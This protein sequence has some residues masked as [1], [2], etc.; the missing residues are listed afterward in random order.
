MKIQPIA[1][2][3]TVTIEIRQPMHYFDKK[4]NQETMDVW[5]QACKDFELRITT[6]VEVSSARFKLDMRC[7]LCNNRWEVFE[8]LPQCCTA[9]RDSW[10]PRDHTPAICAICDD[11][12]STMSYCGGVSP[13]CPRCD[14]NSGTSGQQEATND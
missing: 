9:A 1:T 14:T 2:G 4:S 12:S 8:D 5:R 11:T 10:K 3:A 13:L 6:W 7:P